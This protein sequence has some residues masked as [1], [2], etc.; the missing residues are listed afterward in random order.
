MRIQE[1]QK[2]R[3]WKERRREKDEKEKKI[4]VTHT[5]TREGEIQSTKYENIRTKRKVRCEREK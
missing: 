1:E 3:N 4:I 5:I 2:R